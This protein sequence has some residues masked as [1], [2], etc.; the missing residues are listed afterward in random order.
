MSSNTN[1]NSERSKKKFLALGDSYTIG[2]SVEINERWPVRLIKQLN[3]KNI[4][5][6]DLKIVATTGWTTSE[7]AA[8]ITEEIFEPPYDLV[9]LLIGVNNQYRG[10]DKNKYRSE[11]T[12]L[13][14]QAIDFSGGIRSNV[15]VISIPDWSNTP[16]ADNKNRAEIATEIDIY[17]KINL[18]QCDLLE[19]KFMDITPISRKAKQD[20]TLIAEDGL[21]PSGKMYEQWVQLMFPIVEKILSD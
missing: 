19:V 14:Y 5:I 1:D 13:I 16:F 12:D 17:N 18:E 7:L 2:E 8:K 11:L 6:S 15:L 9:T 20:P 4:Q 21:H 3:E 10:E